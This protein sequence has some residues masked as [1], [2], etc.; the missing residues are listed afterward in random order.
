VPFL[1]IKGTFIYFEIFLSIYFDI[2][3]YCCYFTSSATKRMQNLKIMKATTLI[4]KLKKMNI[5]FN[6]VVLND[7][8][9]T[10]EF[11]INGKK[12]SADWNVGEEN[13]HSFCVELG[14]CESSQETQRRFFDNFSQVL[15]NSVK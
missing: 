14:Y 4:S 5:N 13:V 15:K 8:N 2:K 11:S 12:Y 10:I 6:L 1:A 9:R 7:Y 3:I